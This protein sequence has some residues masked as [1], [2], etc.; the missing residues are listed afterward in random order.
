MAQ[1]FLG[2]ITLFGCNFAPNG[3]ALCQGQLMAI[4]QNTALFS[5]LGTNYGGNGTSTFGLPN[6]QGRVALG[7]GQLVGG[8]GYVIGEEAGFESVTLTAQEL[9][10]HTHPFVATTGTASTVTSAGN[11]FGQGQLG[12]PVHGLSKAL[13][14]STLSPTPTLVPLNPTSLSPYGTVLPVGHENRQPFLALSYCI[15]LVGIFPARG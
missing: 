2:Q 14:Y 1:P 7:Y 11:Q 3:W 4:S 6:L 5:L 10:S 13:S 9:P 15:A 8:S 12:N